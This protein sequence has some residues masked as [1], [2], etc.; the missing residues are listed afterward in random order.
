[1]HYA[2][3]A[4]L[5]WDRD[6]GRTA[7]ILNSVFTR[8]GL[9][10][11][12]LSPP[13][14]GG[15]LSVKRLL[16]LASVAEAEGFDSIWVPDDAPGIGLR[17]RPRFEAYTLLGALATGTRSARLGALVTSVTSRPPSL[18]AKQV[19]T[20]DLLSSGRAVLG[21]GAGRHD[22]R[23]VDPREASVSLTERFE[24]LEEALKV[25]HAMFTEDPVHFEGRHYRLED[26]VNR[27]HPVQQGG[28]PML[29]GGN[30]EDRTLR[31]V[32][33][34]AEACNLS[35]DLPTIR[36]M[37]SA[38]AGHCEAAGR[39]PMSITK[40]MLATLV[41][42]ESEPCALELVEELRSR[43]QTD[44]VT[45]LSTVIAGSPDAV[46][47][48]VASF[49]EVGIDSLIVNLPGVQ[50]GELIAVAADVVSKSF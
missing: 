13:G 17:D 16:A 1:M 20:L 43:P 7:S 38:L 47:R 12:G 50:E 3:I 5:T 37:L 23:D 24:R 11:P 39:D 36:R 34:F 26:A 8:L 19:T 45:S 2:L 40:T 46:A 48:Q 6:I 33:N 31:L 14:S 30:G 22:P 25:F 32:A 9:V 10:V 15:N 41:I 35:G 49:R 18:L 21:V 4:R 27:P 28:P 29:I 42:S 44:N